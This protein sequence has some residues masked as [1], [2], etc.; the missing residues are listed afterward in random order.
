MLVAGKLFQ[1]SLTNTPAQYEST[2]VIKLFPAVI[3][4][5]L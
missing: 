4:E 2:N 1:P 3:Y 5:R